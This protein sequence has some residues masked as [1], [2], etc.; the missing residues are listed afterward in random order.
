MHWVFDGCMLLVCGGVVFVCDWL[1][2]DFIVYG[3]C[4]LGVGVF[5]W[6]GG[7]LVTRVMGCSCLIRCSRMLRCLWL[8]CRRILWI[9]TGGNL[10]QSREILLL[11]P[12]FSW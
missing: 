2:L 8:N 7:L 4:Y 9:D 11:E 12:N 5:W 10:L 1:C 6:C 3:R